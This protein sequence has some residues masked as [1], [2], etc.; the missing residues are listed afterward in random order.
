[1]TASATSLSDLPLPPEPGLLETF[2]RGQRM[3]ND[4]LAVTLEMHRQNGTVVGQRLGPFR[5]VSLF[6]PDAVKLVLLNREG[7]F[8]NK[9]AWD[10]IIGKIFPNG[11]MLRDGDDHRYHRRIMLSAFR[12]PALE[13]YLAHMNGHIAERLDHWAADDSL[14]AYPALKR[15]TLE[16]A[17]SVFLGI[18]LGPEAERVNRAFEGTVAASMAMV[19]VPIPGLTWTKGLEGRRY[20]AEFLRQMIPAKRTDGASDMFSQ[21]CRAESEEGDK[22]SDQEIIDHMI[23]LM[24]AAHDTTASTLTSMIYELARH[25]EWQDRI[26]RESHALGKDT[27]AFSD[28]DS[29]A[30]VALAMNETLRRYPPLSTMPRVATRDFE[31]EGKR[32]PEN[33]M[34]IVYPI[35]THYMSEWWSDPF[36]F[37]PERFTAARAEHKR[38]S[39]NFVPF[40]G[41]A[42]MCIGFRFAEMQ[43]AAIMHQL[44]RRFRWSVPASYI[45]PVQQSPISK[46]R[47]NLPVRMERSG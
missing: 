31:I 26:R 32:I 37:D 45:M 15:L 33:T 42:H 6:G 11:L 34:V 5:T 13:T 41:G 14:L 43:I 4:P 23:F 17:C 44:V 1:M 39:H 3:R 19:R 18:A 28:L 46:P 8:S 38:H 7:I 36:A 35:H 22:Y 29:E 12:T 10:L 47:D 24:M 20:L 9:R 16:L 30:A 27:I 21:L 2:R 25:P 40:G